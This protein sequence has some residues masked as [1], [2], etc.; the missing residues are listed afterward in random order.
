MQM[1]DNIERPQR[2]ILISIDTGDYDAEASLEEL[3]ELMRSAGG[4]TIATV[5]Q[6]RD[7]PD[8]ATC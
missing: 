5:S 7:K 4:E 2:A 8:S 6:K 1:Y 3:K